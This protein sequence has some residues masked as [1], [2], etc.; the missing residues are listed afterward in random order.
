MV[1]WKL[2]SPICCV[3][4]WR[5]SSK[6]LW[7]LTPFLPKCKIEKNLKMVIYLEW[8]SVSWKFWKSLNAK[9]AISGE[10][11]AMLDTCAIWPWYSSLR[12]LKRHFLDRQYRSFYMSVMRSEAPSSTI[13]EILSFENEQNSPIFVERTTFSRSEIFSNII[14]AYTGQEQLPCFLKILSKHYAILIMPS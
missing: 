2:W 11:R 9:V 6:L 4:V 3:Q 8:N 13:T 10:N 1:S 7:N 14:V 12:S 5:L